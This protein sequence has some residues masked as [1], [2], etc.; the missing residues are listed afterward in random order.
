MYL[1]GEKTG[2]SWNIEPM[3]GRLFFNGSREKEIVA[4]QGDDQIEAF[5]G[6]IDPGY[7]DAIDTGTRK[8]IFSDAVKRFG[9]SELDEMMR[10]CQIGRLR[11]SNLKRPK[12]FSVVPY[13]SANTDGGGESPSKG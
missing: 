8:P 3:N 12:T 11:I 4:G 1:W 5:I 7:V 13:A 9:P 2:Q 10:D 6:V